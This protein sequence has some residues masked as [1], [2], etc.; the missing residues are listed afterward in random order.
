MSLTEPQY[1]EP[2]LSVTPDSLRCV[3]RVQRFQAALRDWQ[4]VLS[5]CFRSAGVRIW[6]NSDELITVGHVRS[7][8]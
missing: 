5:V 8:G 2:A 3:K 6:H 4:R 1:W 7:L